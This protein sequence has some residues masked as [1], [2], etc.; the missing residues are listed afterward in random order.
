MAALIDIKQQKSKEPVG[1]PAYLSDCENCARQ[2]EE[3]FS[4]PPAAD[5]LT[6]RDK[7]FLTR[8]TIMRYST[9]R[10][11][12]FK[13]ALK[14]L[15]ATLEWRV[16]NV[17][18][19]LSCPNCPSDPF[20][21]CF[22][23]I[24]I[25]NLKRVVIY[26]NAAKA[27]INEKEG[28]VQHMCHTLE[29][30][31]RSTDELG[32]HPQWVWLVDFKGF[33]MWNAMQSSTS[34]ATITTF[35]THMPERMG[36]VILINPPSIFDILFRAMRPFIDART[37]GKINIVRGDSRTIAAEMVKFGID[38]SDDGNLKTIK[39]RFTCSS[40]LYLYPCCSVCML[41]Y[42]NRLIKVLMEWAPGWLN[43]WI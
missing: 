5:A 37:M 20:S 35:S 14:N 31:W 43:A 28:A 41:F 17:P 8:P 38:S 42:L 19:K 10:D 33:S 22:Y 25:D 30:A 4:S 2:L 29:H 3:Y 1:S 24:G 32:L 21:H 40:C 26:A 6:P 36:L 39:L 34:S 7:E 27:K 16:T 12:D 13:D 15:K 11:A 18:E 23:C 9:A